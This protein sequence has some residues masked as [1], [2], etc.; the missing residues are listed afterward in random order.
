MFFEGDHLK[1]VNQ[2]ISFYVNNNKLKIE[3]EKEKEKE[4][5]YI[6]IAIMTWK[7]DLNEELKLRLDGSRIMDSIEELEDDLDYLD[8]VILSKHSEWTIDELKEL[9]LKLK[10]SG[11]DIIYITKAE[12]AEEIKTCIDLSIEDFLIEPTALE[13]IR[14]IEFTG[15]NEGTANKGE[16]YTEIKNDN[17][18]DCVQDWD[19]VYD[20]MQ[21]EEILRLRALVESK[22][23]EDNSNIE[24]DVI[25]N[26]NVVEIEKVE[27]VA[28]ENV[29]PVIK[30]KKENAFVFFLN[31]IYKI[32]KLF[33]HV[34]VNIIS[35]IADVIPWL[36][37]GIIVSVAANYFLK[38]Q[39]IDSFPKLME[40]VKEIIQQFIK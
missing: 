16:D 27:P 26:K 12:S 4:G 30:V 1:K 10:D 40:L 13:I 14:R 11:V 7:E 5:G 32:L 24:K 34:I 36:I 8:K 31:Y 6:M 37:G 35:S 21:R 9:L 17:Q 29:Q 15:G 3:K 39:G 20:E 18:L 2:Q 23:D 19:S 28:I 22:E 38:E 25:G 33:V